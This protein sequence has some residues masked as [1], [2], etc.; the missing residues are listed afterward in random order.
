[1]TRPMDRSMDELM[2]RSMNR[3]KSIATSN[4]N[5]DLKT[6][7]LYMLFFVQ[8]LTSQQNIMS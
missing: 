3:F 4:S 7:K 2:D 8:N 6:L 5:H 1:M